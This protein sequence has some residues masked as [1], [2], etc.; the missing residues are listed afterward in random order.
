MLGSED[1]SHVD[2]EKGVYDAGG[3]GRLAEMD[4]LIDY[5]ETEV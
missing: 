1:E 4:E 5:G 3:A 2:R